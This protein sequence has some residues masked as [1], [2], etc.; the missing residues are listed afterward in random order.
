MYIARR[1]MGF[2]TPITGEPI[3]TTLLTAFTLSEAI[4]PKIGAGRTEAD[5][6]VPVQN[7]ISNGQGTGRL[8]EIN[9]AI[10]GATVPTLQ[11]MAAETMALGRYFVE[12]ITDPRFT[13]GRASEQAANTLMPLVDGTGNYSWPEM[14]GVPV[15]LNEW[16]N[17]ANGGTLGTIQR[18]IQSL[19]GVWQGSQLTQYSGP[20]RLETWTPG[21]AYPPQAG[22]LP[23]VSPVKTF[24]SYPTVGTVGSELATVQQYLPWLLAGAFLWFMPKGR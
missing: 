18:K 19:G 13:D 4:F 22:S 11:A 14:R 20:P 23:P 1:G 9:R 16:G 21:T 2:V 10:N 17:P 7:A 12:F 24:S 15:E 3:S 8:D 6:I 5:A